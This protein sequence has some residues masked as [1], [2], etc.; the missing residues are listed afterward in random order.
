MGEHALLIPIIQYGFAG[1]SAILLAILVWLI[2][3]LLGVLHETNQVISKN[4]ETIHYVDKHVITNIAVT[5]DL[6]DR[7]LQR[8]CIREKRDE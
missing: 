4:N 3:R 8:P 1:L 2:Q 7:L 6:R 5:Q